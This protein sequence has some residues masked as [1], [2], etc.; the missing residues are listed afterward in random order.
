MTLDRRGRIPDHPNLQ[1]HEVADVSSADSRGERQH[2]D[3]DV[4]QLHQV[5]EVTHL[6]RHHVRSSG[7]AK[8]HR[9][10]DHRRDPERIGAP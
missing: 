4:R 2:P 7:L 10:V 6:R 9:L 8:Q 5:Q 3:D 1:Q